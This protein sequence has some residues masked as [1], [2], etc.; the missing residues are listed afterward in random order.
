MNLNSLCWMFCDVKAHK[1][2]LHSFPGRLEIPPVAGVRST[3]HREVDWLHVWVVLRSCYYIE[4]TEC[5]CDGYLIRAI[6]MYAEVML[7]CI[8]CSMIL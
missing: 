2:N 8:I 7:Y 4:H 5:L 1:Y 6:S 3:H